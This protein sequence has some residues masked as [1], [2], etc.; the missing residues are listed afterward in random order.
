M[1]GFTLN[2][3]KAASAR[4]RPP[5]MHFRMWWISAHS[6]HWLLANPSLHLCHS[7]LYHSLE[8]WQM[9]V[10]FFVTA[11]KEKKLALAVASPHIAQ[12]WEGQGADTE[13]RGAGTEVRGADIEVA[14]TEVREADTEVADTEADTEV[15][16]A[17]TEVRMADTEVRGADTE[18]RM[19]DTEVRGA[20]TEAVACTCTWLQTHV[21]QSPSLISLPNVA[22]ETVPMLISLCS[23]PSLRT[24]LNV[25]F[26]TVQIS[27][28]H[29]FKED[30]QLLSLST[31]LSSRRLPM[32]C[33]WLCP[34]L[35][36]TS[37]FWDA[38]PLR[39]LL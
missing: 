9:S 1:S 31:P 18:V 36:Y 14:D 13:V 7:C 11:W 27:L 8:N 17:D 19:A 2:L 10:K 29:P 39:Q 3:P 37:V 15:R 26:E 6:K 4:N 24:S 12:R 23:S 28:C 22:F 21:P 35:L 20:D 16:M 38:R 34:K 5:A 25:A 30:H 32:W 33:P